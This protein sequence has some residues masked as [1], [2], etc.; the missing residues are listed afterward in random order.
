MAKRKLVR[1]KKQ[2]NVLDNPDVTLFKQPDYAQQ[3]EV[4][5]IELGLAGGQVLKEK[6][7]FTPEQIAEWMDETLTVAKQKRATMLSKVV[8][9]IDNAR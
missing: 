9:S 5:A 7:S 3:M 1:K 6:F 2:V 4:L 8:E